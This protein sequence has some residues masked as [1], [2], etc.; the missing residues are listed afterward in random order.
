MVI[1]LQD[2]AYAWRRLR[3]APVF[4]LVA[5][6]TLALSIGG[7]VT[8]FSFVDGVLLKPLTYQQSGQLTVLWE[9]VRF[10][11]HLM[12]Y[13]GPNVRQAFAWRQSQTS[14]QDIVLL[15]EDATGISLNGDHPR[16]AGTVRTEPSLLHMLGVQPVLGRDFLAEMAAP[17]TTTA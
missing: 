10:L 17:D 3:R 7:T 8:I 14:F 1:L 13:T 9:R 12:P 5:T 16:F 2:L 15:R 6:L 11:E 4:S